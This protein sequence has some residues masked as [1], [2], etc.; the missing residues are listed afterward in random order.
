MQTTN[1]TLLAAYFDGKSAQARPV[2][3]HIE[4]ERLHVRTAGT[5]FDVPVSQVLWPERTRHGMRIA[6]L[7]TGGIIQC[8]DGPAWDAWCKSNGL[9]E[10][11]IVVLQQSWRWVTG[12]LLALT[13]LLGATYQWGLPVIAQGIV[14]IT[15][16]SFDERIGQ[17]TLTAIDDRLM[18]PSSLSMAQQTSIRDAFAHAL[19]FQAA[20]NVPRWNL[21]FRKSK[22]GPNA[23]ALPGGTILMTDEMVQLVDGDTDVLTAVL[24]HELGH[25]KHRHSLRMLVQVSGLSAV[26]SL[27][28]GD[29]STVLAAIPALMGQAQ[30]SREAEREADDTAMQVLTAAGLNPRVMVTMFEKLE[31]QR[32]SESKGPS[33]G[34]SNDGANVI[35]NLLGL[36]FASHPADSERIAFFGKNS[37]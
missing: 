17:A 7:P 3:L 24:A 18:E 19:R 29:F 15:P 10:S 16:Y 33:S 12:S 28:L 14:A 35:V 13:V 20:D 21:K 8:A 4:R 25:L 1:P 32:Q 30:Y 6:Q 37:R 22:L 36:A 23:L 31:A 27:F 9:Q 34:H 2:E 5:A 11:F 26:T